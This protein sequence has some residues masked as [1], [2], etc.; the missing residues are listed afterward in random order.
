MAATKKQTNLK[1]KASTNPKKENIDTEDIIKDAVEEATEK[2]VE[3]TVNV[4]EAT[5]NETAE[6]NNTPETD[7]V[8]K[9]TNEPVK[10]TI[11]FNP[12]VKSTQQAESKCKVKF[13]KDY[14]GCV[15]GEWFEYRAGETA[16]V[17]P[18]LK[19]IL[20]G[21]DGMLKPL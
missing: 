3:E 7:K 8:A 10:D 13:A 9:I 11:T 18:N 20:T 12:E 6:D 15:G 4:E 1:P 5:E 14:R 2:S 19:R 16:Y 17:S 21:I